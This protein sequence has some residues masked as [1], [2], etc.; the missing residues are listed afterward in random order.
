[1]LCTLRFPSTE[2]LHG[3]TCGEQEGKNLM[4]IILSPKH[5]ANNARIVFGVQTRI[6]PIILA[7]LI[8]HHS[9]IATLHSDMPCINP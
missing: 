4:I 3:F 6:D 2:N 9:S 5:S 1:M 8:A 7:A